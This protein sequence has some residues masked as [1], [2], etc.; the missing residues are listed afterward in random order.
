MNNYL[1]DIIR[2]SWPIIIGQLGMVFTGFFDT[3]MVG[4]LG[5][6]SLAAAGICN[7]VFFFVSVFPIG[8]A[9][10]YATIVGILQG[11]DKTSSYRL[12][13]RD[14]FITT[15]GLSVLASGVIYYF[16]T[17]FSIL[18]QTPAVEALAIPYMT[19]LMWSLLPMMVFF[20]AKNLCDGFS[21][22]IG[23]MVITLAAL[24]LNVFLNW[25]F[26]Y[27][28]LGFEA[29][30]L[31]GAGYA[32]IISRVFLAVSMMLILFY[33]KRIPI[34]W[35]QFIGSFRESTRISFYQR[36]FAIG[37][38]SGLQYF[39]E[40]AAFAGAAVMA[41]WLGAQELA[42]HNLAI[43]L[44]SVT[45][46]FAG[47]I[48]AGSS[49]CMARAYGKNN[50]QNVKAYGVN[51]LKI[52]FVVTVL[53]AIIFY[54]FNNP[55]AALFTDEPAVLQIGAELLFIAAVFQ[56]SDGIQAI[57]VGI[58]RGIE[59]VAVPSAL[60]FIAY[61]IIAMPIGYYLSHYSSVDALYHGVNGIWI[62]LCIGL[63]ISATFLSY[64][65]YYL[66]RNQ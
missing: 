66:L 38:P 43:T 62:G 64:R 26:I 14:S 32:T 29:Y 39:F 55:L 22:T 50:T 60:I 12:L 28:H 15:I 34:I 19:L 10:A 36:I 25:V 18:D 63:T 27:G 24:V 59:D 4:K 21:Y 58:L 56:L 6:E 41:G 2:I 1:K 49:I 37:F 13:A 46:M 48:S 3:L 61:W 33:S 35:S 51:G 20:F 5:Y 31:N 9:M 42:A 57:S 45:Y 40:V 7:S 53:F 52:G 17:H 23:G 16:V 54:L 65:F 8:V 30:G 47:G 11:K 44:A